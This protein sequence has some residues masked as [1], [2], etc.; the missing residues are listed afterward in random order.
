MENQKGMS[1]LPI[2]LPPIYP[3]KQ[4]S[5]S[6]RPPRSIQPQVTTPTTT[7]P[8]VVPAAALPPAP[9]RQILSHD[10]WEE[11]K[12][13]IYRLYIEENMAFSSVAKI[14]HESHGFLPTKRQ[15]GT[16][17]AKWGFK[18]NA[19]KEERKKLL[20]GADPNREIVGFN[21]QKVKRAKLARWEKEMRRES[22]TQHRGPE[23][24]SPEEEELGKRLTLTLI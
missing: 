15:F 21:G 7:M 9:T 13:L 24:G 1:S 11:L 8:E 4:G 2:Q 17:L 3:Q 14:I 19:T 20:I 10:S 6:Q 12:P 22:R 16:R 23:E 18:K 5:P